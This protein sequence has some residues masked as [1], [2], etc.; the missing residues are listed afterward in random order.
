MAP[1][2]ADNEQM[3]NTG[4]RSCYPYPYTA[5]GPH[6]NWIADRRFSLPEYAAAQWIPSDILLRRQD[7]RTNV[8]YANNQ[9]SASNRGGS[10]SRLESRRGYTQE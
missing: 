10:D 5:I 1:A 9:H 6:A 8:F 2:A 7:K 3:L 4:H